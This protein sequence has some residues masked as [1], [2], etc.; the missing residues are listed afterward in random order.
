MDWSEDS[1]DPN[2]F[3][4]ITESNEMDCSNDVHDRNDFLPCTNALPSL[5]QTLSSEEDTR[6]DSEEEYVNYMASLDISDESNVSVSSIDTDIFKLRFQ[7]KPVPLS[8]KAEDLSPN[9]ELEVEPP[10]PPPGA[11]RP[12]RP[13]Y[14][15]VHYPVTPVDPIYKEQ[16]FWG[17]V[18]HC[19]SSC[20]RV[21][22][23]CSA[24]FSARF[25]AVRTQTTRQTSLR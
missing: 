24:K 22:K 12:M 18:R 2:D 25:P 3:L 9:V 14:F 23:F 19:V 4:Q 15:A 1:L 16:Y 21:T 6:Y 10:R 11:L 20:G 5:S 13:K 17:K 8:K 7:W